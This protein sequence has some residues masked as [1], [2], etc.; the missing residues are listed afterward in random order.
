M[1]DLNGP[2]LTRDVGQPV[3]AVDPFWDFLLGEVDEAG[4]GEDGHG[5]QDEEEAELL[6]SLLEGVEQGLEAGKV[7]DQLEDPRGQLQSRMNVLAFPD[8]SRN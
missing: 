5:H 6:V 7:S 4:V 3:G 1:F 2:M 8:T